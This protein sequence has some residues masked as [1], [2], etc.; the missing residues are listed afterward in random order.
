MSNNIHLHKND[1]PDDL[2]LGNIIAVDGEFMGLNVRR[3]PLCL[4]Q[5]SS[6]NSDAH[7]VQ[8]DRDNYNAPN[9]VKLLK[10]E[11]VSK[12][13]HYGRADMSHIK[14]Y[15]KTETNNILD[16]K[17]ASKLARSYSDNH[18]LK[19]LIKE[20]A[21]IDI[22]KQ[23]QSSDFGGQLS[24]AQLKYCANDVIYLHKIHDNLEKIL[25]RENR[26]KLYK[27]CLKFLKTRVDLDLALFKDDIWSH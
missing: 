18:S 16:T 22:S 3:D 5:I 4:I 12:I 23:F 15:L 14:Y 19:T 11:N 26:I 13:F 6:G 20:F 8:F 24:P 9:L 10:D 17:I 27:D 25:E 1:L 2:K 7:I 21:N